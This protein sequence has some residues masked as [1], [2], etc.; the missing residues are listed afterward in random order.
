M[1]YFPDAPT[2]RGVKHIQ[3]LIRA[4]EAGY[5]SWICFVVQMEGI[6][7]LC[8]NEETHPAFGAALRSAQAAGVEIRAWGCKVQPERVEIAY[9][10]PVWL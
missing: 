6:R 9:P 8:P 3:G 10:V 5:H 7:G 2:L 4:K 1:A